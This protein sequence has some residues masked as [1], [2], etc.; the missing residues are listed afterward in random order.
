MSTVEVLDP[1][2]RSLAELAAE[3][4]NEYD[5]GM[6]AALDALQHW[7]RAGDALRA[8][9]QQVIPGS[10]LKWLD[11]NFRGQRSKAQKLIRFATYK[12]L[13]AAEGITSVDVASRYLRGLPDATPRGI[14]RPENDLLRAEVSRLIQGGMTHRAVGELLG[15]SRYTIYR[16]QDPERARRVGREYMAKRR[17]AERATRIEGQ[18]ARQD[19]AVR[20]IGGSVADAYSMIRKTAQVVDRACGDADNREVRAALSAALTKLHHAEDEIVRALGIA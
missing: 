19:A 2:V 17:A 13:I 16:W 20:R 8:A 5:A 6:G 18:S 7:I 14:H 3:A 15:V 12:D 10:W 4:Q 1:G 9:K 11:D